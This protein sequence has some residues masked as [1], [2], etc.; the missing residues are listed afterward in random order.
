[1]QIKLLT[2]LHTKPERYWI[3]RGQKKALTLFHDMAQRVPAYRDFL[4]KKEIHPNSIQTIEDFQKI[5][6][7]SKQDY[8]RQYSLD[9]LSWNGTLSDKQNVI[10]MTSGT[11]GEP[12]YFPRTQEQDLQYAQLAE[13]YL[14]TNFE[15]H[16][17]STLYIVGFM[18]GAW[19]GGLFTY[20]ALSLL[21]KRGKYN[22]SIITPGVDKLS[23]INAVKK[24]GPYFDQVI[25]GSYAP[26]LKD[27]LDDGERL[28]LDWKKYNLRFVFSAEGFSEGVRD[29]VTTIA[30]NKNIYTATLN[31][32]GTV[33]L[34][35]MSYETPLSIL[36]RRT[37]LKEKNIFNDLFGN[38]V[39]VPTLTQYIPELFYFEEIDKTVIC[40]A[41]SGLPLVRYDLKD[42]GGVYSFD[43]LTNLFQANHINLVEQCKKAKIENTVWNLPFVYVFERNDLMVKYYLCDVYPETIKKAL[44]Q[45]DVEH[46]VTGKFTMMVKFDTN[47]NQYVEINV[48]LKAQTNDTQELNTMITK[49]ITD[50]LLNENEGYRAVYN[51]IGK[52]AIPHI[53]FWPYEDPAFFRP[54]TKQKWVN[55]N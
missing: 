30:G 23:I 35:T 2:E 7:I 37:A 31:H 20:S 29:Y 17:K 18:M 33:D 28:G 11:T 13:L 10:S 42:I 45:S 19:I 9:E 25:I 4:A 36:A 24:L 53:I 50:Q 15:I 14:R 6:T 12:F 41:Y 54:G 43:K 40:S 52:R 38:T 46:M 16:K 32:Y 26:F 21:A 39:K 22:M 1:M 34:G 8:L 3:K 5:P 55:K 27:V 51:H 44:Q 47:Q 48:E 49:K